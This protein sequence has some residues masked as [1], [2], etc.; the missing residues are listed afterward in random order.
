MPSSFVHAAIG[1]TLAIGLLGEFYDRRALAVVLAVVLLPEIDTFFGYLMDGA[2]RTVLH[3]MVISAVGAAGLY[4]DSTREHSWLRDRFGARGVRL[5]W[6]ALLVH[7]FAHLSLD[8]AHLSGINVL[9]PF[10]DRFFSLDGEAYLSAGEG[11]VQTFVEFADESGTGGAD[12]DVGQ[13]GTTENTHVGSPA[14]P[15]KDPEPGPVD[16]RFPI[17][18]QGWQ[19]YFVLTGLFALAARKLQTPQYGEEA[20]GDV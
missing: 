12:I 14:Q 1:F 5:A 15:S 17:A 16:R 11:F 20:D 9:W 19:L 10:V 8:W 7:T 13:S 4:W 6:V 3:N 2:H 18:V